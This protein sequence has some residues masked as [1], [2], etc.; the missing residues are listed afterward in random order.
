M[1]GWPT[2]TAKDA[3]SSAQHGERTPAP[4]N[5]HSGTT[6]LDAARMAGWP[7][8]RATD[9]DKGVRTGDGTLTEMDRNHGQLGCD[10]PTTAMLAGWATPAARDWRSNEASEE[11]HARRLEETRGKP[12]SEQAHQLTR[13]E[14]PS[15]SPASTG[16]R[17][18]L[19][20]AHS[21]WLMGLPRE[22]DDCVPTETRSSRK[23]PRRSS[24]P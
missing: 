23:S 18:Q 10:L 16:R 15:G 24:E 11:H 7:T 14:T 21:R 6:L 12:L 8:A 20:P 4:P 1:A 19:N 2:T 3:A 5:R 9:G 17:G 13:G 22:W